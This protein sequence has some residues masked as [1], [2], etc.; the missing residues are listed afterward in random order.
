MVIVTSARF[1]SL[2]LKLYASVVASTLPFSWTVLNLQFANS[3]TC[4]Q[5]ALSAHLAILTV[6]I[7]VIT[8]YSE[9]TGTEGDNW[10]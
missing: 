5:P 8:V 7:Q 1:S 2:S 9:G 6:L 4:L 10:G 3:F